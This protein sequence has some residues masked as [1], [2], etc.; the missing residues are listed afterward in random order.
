MTN[1]DRGV[2]YTGMSSN[3]PRR[4]FEH[5]NGL[6]PGFTRKYNL[7]RLVWFKGFAEAGLAAKQEQRIKRWRRDWKIA[8]VEAENPHWLDLSDRTAA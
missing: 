1:A 8:L 5:S 2:F 6:I 4:V 3:L 7:T